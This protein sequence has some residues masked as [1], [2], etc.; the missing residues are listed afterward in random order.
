[1]DSKSIAHELS[2]D[3]YLKIR[4]QA[5]KEIN[6]G[7]AEEIENKPEKHENPRQ[8]QPHHAL[9]KTDPKQEVKK[10]IAPVQHE[11]HQDPVSILN[12]I[13]D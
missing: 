13:P 4:S 5:I 6:A 11:K 10:E 9:T 1:M 12:S 7:Y 2:V 8:Q 3:D